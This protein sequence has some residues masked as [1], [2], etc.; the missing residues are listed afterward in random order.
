M[1]AHILKLLT[2]AAICSNP[3]HALSSIQ[4]KMLSQESPEYV[5]RVCEWVEN[6]SGNQKIVEY[7]QSFRLDITAISDLH[8]QFKVSGGE[9]NLSVLLADLSI[10]RRSAT[11]TSAQP[12]IAIYSDDSINV[13]SK[14]WRFGFL[15]LPHNLFRQAQNS[16]FAMTTDR[17]PVAAAQQ[18]DFSRLF[19]GFE[20]AL[21]HGLYFLK[22]SSAYTEDRKS[23]TCSKMFDQAQ[24]YPAFRNSTLGMFYSTS[25]YDKENPWLLYFIRSHECRI[26]GERHMI[27]ET[28][29]PVEN[30]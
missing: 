10:A 11:L 30:S 16:L 28:I 20:D 22:R 18:Y 27:L 29:T 15:S 23:G 24:S 5:Y 2:L 26:D 9:Y 17:R 7:N 12:E 19:F 4:E 25:M 1:K 13:Q 6:G 3:L 21:S 14:F 8:T